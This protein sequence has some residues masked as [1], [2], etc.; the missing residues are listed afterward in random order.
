MKFTDESNE[1]PA[2]PS[3]V[4][5]VGGT[6]RIVKSCKFLYKCPILGTANDFD[7]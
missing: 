6:E 1:S 4:S 3:I 7:I 2:G 5:L